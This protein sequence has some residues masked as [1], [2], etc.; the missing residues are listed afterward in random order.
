MM[1]EKL[2]GLV[3]SMS[4]LSPQPDL[5]SLYESVPQRVLEEL[6]KSGH[7]PSRIEIRSDL[8]FDLLEEILEKAGCRV[9]WVDRMLQMDEAIMSMIS[10]LS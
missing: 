7:R 4:V 6:I 5:E 10:H 1:V 8:L 9:M 3:V 2:N